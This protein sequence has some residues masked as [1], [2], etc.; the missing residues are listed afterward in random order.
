VIAVMGYYFLAQKM[1]VGHSTAAL[2][3]QRT[4]PSP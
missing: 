4:E 3:A 1:T 2:V